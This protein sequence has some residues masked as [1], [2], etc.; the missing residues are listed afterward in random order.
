VDTFLQFFMRK[1]MI[2]SVSLLFMSLIALSLVLVGTS[3][4]M[5]ETV[6]SPRNAPPRSN[7]SRLSF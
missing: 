3:S 5:A 2:S 7:T 4:R 1:E 6:A